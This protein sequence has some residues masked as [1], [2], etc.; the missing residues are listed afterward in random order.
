MMRIDACLTPINLVDDAPRTVEL[1][2][3][4]GIAGCFWPTK[5]VAETVA[6]RAFPHED[7]DTRYA[8]I[9]CDRFVRE[10]DL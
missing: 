1:W 6:R 5:M 4:Q 9:F 3:V 10:K 8:R 7:I 2:H